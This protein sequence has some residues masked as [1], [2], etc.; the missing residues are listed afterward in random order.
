[1]DTSNPTKWAHPDH[2]R[3]S[4]SATTWP[5]YE[6]YPTI[7]R[8]LFVPSYLNW[9]QCQIHAPEFMQPAQIVSPW[10][11]PPRIPPRC[12]PSQREKCS[13]ISTTKHGNLIRLVLPL[14][15][16]PA[17]LS[18]L[19][20]RTPACPAL[21]NPTIPTPTTIFPIRP[22]NTTSSTKTMTN[23]LPMCS[24]LAHSQTNLR[25]CLQRLHVWIPLHVLWWQRLFFCYVPLQ[26]KHH[27]CNSNPR[28]WIR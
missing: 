21:S 19:P 22:N 16:N 10:S 3:C 24:A 15:K 1:M 20:S 26:N 4:A 12:S 28:A 25:C 5:L 8:Q 7:A 14:Q 13:Q 2:P 18:W 17:S 11:H 9:K 6:W 23:P 27:P